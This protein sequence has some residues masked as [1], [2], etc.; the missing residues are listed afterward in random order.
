[1]KHIFGMAKSCLDPKGANAPKLEFDFLRLA[2]AVAKFRS[3]GHDAQGYLMVLDK[4]VLKRMSGWAS[5]YGFGEEVCLE[6]GDLTGKQLDCLSREKEN[7]REGMRG[8]SSA[9]KSIAKVG[10]ELGEQFLTTVIYEREPG[11]KQIADKTV[12]PLG[13]NWDFYGIRS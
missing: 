2:Y 7:N 1:M 3:Q 9:E 6:C 12:L 4:K 11:V 8:K 5:K 10:K 13:V